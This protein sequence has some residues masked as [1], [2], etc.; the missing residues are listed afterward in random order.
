MP[1]TDFYELLEVE[2]N[3]DF[4][5]IK[6]SY[7]KLAMKYHPDRNPGDKAAEQKFKDINVAY[8][9]LKDEQKRAAYDRYG[10]NAFNNGFGSG[11]G[12]NGFEF[13]FGGGGFSDMFSEIF[14][15]FMGGGAYNRPSYAQNGADIRYDLQISLEDAFFGVEKEIQI[16]TTQSCSQCNGHGTADGKEAPVCSFCNG[17][18][19]VRMRQGGFFIVEQA[20]PHCK[21]TG[22]LAKDKCKTCGGQ[23]FVKAQKTLKVNIPAGIETGTR[24]RISGA[25]TSG[26]RGGHDG[27]LYVFVDV[28]KHNTFTRDGSNL[29]AE[30]P[31]GFST[32]ALGDTISFASI[33]GQDIEVQIPAGVQSGDKIKIADGGMPIINTK[34]KGNLFIKVNVKTPKNL[35]PRQ[36]ELLEEFAQIEKE[37]PKSFFDKIF[38]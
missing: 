11:G 23:G 8:E 1:E 7:R 10:K 35:T 17:T 37:A 13:N 38:K 22:R 5:T 4:D 2:R 25:G 27:D 32:A 21:G 20:C 26:L 29:Y 33:S 9:V 15:E 6:K 28:K 24:I 3:A 30:L 18:G 34:Q 31:I 14:S 36:K 19:K 12:F 16:N